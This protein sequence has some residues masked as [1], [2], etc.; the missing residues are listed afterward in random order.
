[1]R[2]LTVE[3]LLKRYEEKKALELRLHHIL[4]VG[5]VLLALAWWIVTNATTGIGQ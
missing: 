1:M 5:A 4:F 3:D 2:R